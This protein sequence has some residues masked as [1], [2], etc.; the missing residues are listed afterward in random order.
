MSGITTNRLKEPERVPITQN[1]KPELFSKSGL[2]ALHQGA[3]K[4]GTTKF[5]SI[6]IF[7]NWLSLI[8]LPKGVT[9]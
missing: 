2:Y 8:I 6:P 1:S 9:T 7:M 5:L 3:G 4:S